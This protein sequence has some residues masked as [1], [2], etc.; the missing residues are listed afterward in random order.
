MEYNADEI[1]RQTIAIFKKA[2]K[3][4]K[5]Y[6]KMELKTARIEQN[7]EDAFGV[8]YRMACNYYHAWNGELDYGNTGKVK[9]FIELFG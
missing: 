5:R 7:A 9:E 1:R 6:E 4:Y 3:K 2:I 8:V